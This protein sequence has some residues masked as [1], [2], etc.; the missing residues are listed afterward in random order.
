MIRIVCLHR[1]IY[2][3]DTGKQSD[4]IAGSS[5]NIDGNRKVDELVCGYSV[6]MSPWLH[7]R[8]CLSSILVAI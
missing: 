4:S 5:S 2:R 6:E 1:S 8:T 7:L 3:P